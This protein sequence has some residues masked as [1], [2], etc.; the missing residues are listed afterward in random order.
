VDTPARQG[1]GVLIEGGYVLTNAHVL[2]PFQEA[3]LVFPDG[4]RHPSV[5]LVGWDL[6]ADLAVLGP[7]DTDTAPAV[8]SRDE[9]V[10]IGSE[11][12]LIGHVSGEE[13]PPEP[14]I[15]RGI[16]TRIRE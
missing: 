10:P 9:D 3:N 8:F 15:S 5:P 11:V 13:E 16:V 1:S 14:T 4:S 7:V 6:M 2:W 12:Y